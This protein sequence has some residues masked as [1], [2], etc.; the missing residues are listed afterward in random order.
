MSSPPAIPVEGFAHAP[1]EPVADIFGRLVAAQGSGGA[2]LTIYRGGEPVVDL[3]GGDYARDSLQLLFS[4]SKLISAIAAA[5]ASEA[6][7]IDLDAPLGDYWPAFRRSSTT[8]ITLRM[9]LTHRSGLAA[10]DEVVPFE[11]LL[12]DGEEA[13]IERQDPY[14]EPD[15]R[16]G[17]HAFTFGTLVNGAFTRV[18]GESVGEYVAR[19][20]ATPLGLDLWI[21]MPES[22]RARLHPIEYLPARVTTGRQE[23]VRRS[24]IPKGSTGALFDRF[25]V[26]NAPETASACWPSTS[27][28]AGARDLARLL[29]ATIGD[30]DGHRLLDEDAVTRMCAP[31]SRGVDEVLGFETNFGTGVQL[32]FPQLPLLGPTSFGHEAAGGSVAFADRDSELTVGFTTSIHPAMT[33]ASTSFLALLPTIR[34][35][36]TR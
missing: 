19:E 14:W 36:L 22:E 11:T 35:C 5:R 31:R 26:F 2:A 28:V 27:G 17:Y 20:M 15:T 30:V 18:L 29:A 9:V 12:E 13:A 6:G 34:H 24:V 23:W 33:G 7:L 10:V 3:T 8:S 21:G 4:V 16:H 25:D 32:P 1:F